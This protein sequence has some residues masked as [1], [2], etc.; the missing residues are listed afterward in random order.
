MAINFKGVVILK[1]E[2]EGVGGGTEW[3][4]LSEPCGV[5]LSCKVVVHCHLV[6]EF[7]NLF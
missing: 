4:N 1:N 2:G 7:C 3:I 5:P 6:A